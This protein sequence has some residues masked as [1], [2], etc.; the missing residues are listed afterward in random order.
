LIDGPGEIRFE[1]V[2]FSYANGGAP[3]LNGFDLTVPAGESVA[4]VGSTGSGKTTLAR[5]IPRF[6]DVESGRV[7]LDGVDV[8]DLLVRDLRRAVAV[9]FE[10]TFL[11]T[12]T[13]TG[14]IAFAEPGAS[15]ERVL[16][17]A[18]LAGAHGFISELPRG[19]DTLL[20]ERG[21]HCRAA[22]ASASPWQEPS[23]PTPES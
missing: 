14:N 11:F 21:S 5:L 20:G 17:A 2:R 9:V 18:K 13:V 8:R 10:D 3:I 16:S 23:W 1:N 6:Y 7:T 15:Y 4:V 19:Y 22:N 12:D